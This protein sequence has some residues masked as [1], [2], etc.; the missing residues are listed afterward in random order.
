VTSP[1]IHRWAESTVMP[2]KNGG[3]STRELA[4]TPADGEFHWRLSVAEVSVPGPFSVFPGV[5]RIIVLLSGEGMDLGF[6]DGVV[7][8]RPPHGVHAFAGERAVHATPVGSATTDLNL[9][10]RR[11]RWS[12]SF[13]RHVG[14]GRSAAELLIA[15]VAEGTVELPDGRV[16]EAGDAIERAGS[17]EWTGG[18]VVLAFALRRH[19]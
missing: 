8:L 4:R 1:R 19:V 13:D 11:D 10:M 9:M 5:D 7:P 2:W 15:Y 14:E 12:A 17:L 18:G 6:D 16:A 3:G